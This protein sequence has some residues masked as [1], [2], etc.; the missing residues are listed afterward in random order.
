MFIDD[1]IEKMKQD[2]ARKPGYQFKSNS[3]RFH[4]FSPPRKG[5]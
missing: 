1:T 5:K 3:K 4:E 2:E